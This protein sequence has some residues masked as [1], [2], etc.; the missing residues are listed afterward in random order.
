MAWKKDYADG[1]AVLLEGA[2][3]VGKSTIAEHFARS[4]YRSYILID[5]SK[6]TKNFESYKFYL[7]DTGLF[8]T[9]MFIDRPVIENNVYAKL[10]LRPF[11]LTSFLM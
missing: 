10:L 3:R 8:V 5:F 9:L 4:E 6:V 11:Y 7:S 2:R 1:Y